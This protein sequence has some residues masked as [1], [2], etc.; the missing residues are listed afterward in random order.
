DR[1]RPAHR[2]A[3]A[4]R[5]GG[6]AA[7]ALVSGEAGVDDAE[8]A[9]ARGAPLADPVLDETPHRPPAELAGTTESAL[10]KALGG[11]QADEGQRR[12]ARPRRGAGQGGGAEEELRLPERRWFPAC[13]GRHQ[14][15]PDDPLGR[16]VARR[17][18]GIVDLLR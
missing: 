11:Q 4:N 16:V 5:L 17:G 3:A 1:P 6:P 13:G 10:E 14:V 15:E 8:D 2:R 9:C 12:P 7:L 18:A